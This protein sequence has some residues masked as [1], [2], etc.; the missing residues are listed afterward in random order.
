VNEDQK[1][2]AEAYIR[3]LEQAHAFKKPVVT[4]VE[5]SKVFYPAEDYH[6]DYLVR[7]PDQLYIVINDVPKIEHLRTRFPNVY[8]PEPVLVAPGRS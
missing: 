1:R 4:T 3:Q 8:R 2:I 5:P 6:Q 7:H